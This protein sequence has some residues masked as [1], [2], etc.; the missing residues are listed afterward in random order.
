MFLLY[1]MLLY[2]NLPTICLHIFTIKHVF[3]WW[4]MFEIGLYT[5]T[6]TTWL[7]L[8]LLTLLKMLKSLYKMFSFFFSIRIIVKSIQYHSCEILSKEIKFVAM[9]VI[10]KIDSQFQWVNLDLIE[11]TLSIIIYL[12]NHLYLIIYYISIIL[13]I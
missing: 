1:P 7:R 3:L 6:Y 5:Y 12:Y 13:I 8:D 2:Q 4:Y 10:K 9:G 11:D